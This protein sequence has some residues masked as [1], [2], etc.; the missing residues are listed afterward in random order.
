MN[1]VFFTNNYKPFVGGV[2]IAIENLAQRLRERGNRVYVFAPDYGE[3]Q[4]DDLDVFRCWS[5]RNFN[6]S[7]FALPL[8]LSIERY[9]DFGDLQ[10]D[11]VHVHH[12]FLLGETGMHAARSAELPVVFTYHTQYEKYAHYLP[13]GEKMVGDIAIKLSTR[14]A[15]SCDAII[16][17]SSDVQKLLIERGVRTPIRVIPTGVDLK[18]FKRGN[19]PELRAQYGIPEEAPLLLFVSRLAKEKNVGF[20]I[21]AFERIA[22]VIDDA[23]FLIVG[24]GDDEA[25]LREQAEKT[26]CSKRI[27][28]AGTLGGETLLSAYKAANLFVFSSL[29]ETQGLVVL[30]AMASGVPVVAVDA[31]GVRDVIEENQNGYMLPD[32]EM[33][34]FVAAC[35]TVLGNRSLM[36]RLKEGA[37]KRAKQLSLASTTRRVEDLYR[38]VIRNPHPERHHRFLL[39]REL[40]RYNFDSLAKSLDLNTP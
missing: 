38:Y 35:L 12:P 37:Y 22:S 17:P 25:D 7:K 40:F 18:H 2:P 32:G 4:E 3:K 30:E 31:P 10:A 24:S 26:E 11:I 29:S 33:D 20:L 5:I 21:D 16:A 28:F 8:P 6:D 13:F 36:E 34:G 39:L 9:A 19:G 15:N 14:F 27:V 23:H 1:V